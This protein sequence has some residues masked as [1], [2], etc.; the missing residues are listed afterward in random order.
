M[1]NKKTVCS[2]DMCTGCMACVQKCPNKAIKIYD[3]ILCFNAVIQV[4]KCID[5]GQCYN[6]CQKNS[7][8]D[9]IYPVSWYQGWAEDEK[10][11]MSGS[12]GGVATALSQAFI[13]NGGVVCSCLFEKGDFVFD[14][15]YTIEKTKRFS[16][17][18]YVKS[19]PDGIYK[20]IEQLLKEKKVLF[21]GLP[22]QVAALIKYISGELKQNLYT[23]DLICHGTPSK[24]V[25]EEYLLQHNLNLFEMQS[26][27]FRKKHHYCL[28]DGEKEI[29]AK[30]TCDSYSMSF[31]NSLILTENCYHCDYAKTERVSDITLGDSWGSQLDVAE[32]KKG[33]SL[34]LCQTEKGQEIIELS[35]IHLENV[36]LERAISNNK[37]LCR[38]SIKTE[39]RDVLLRELIRGKGYDSLIF[40]LLPKSS[41][42][43]KIK[44]LL[45][46]FKSL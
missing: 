15:A 18:K 38:P 37:Q 25:L 6:V 19:N 40:K 34:I 13:E 9:L 7:S 30:G 17:S 5:C 28:S 42:K 36:D 43:Q 45:Y 20:Q 32:Q 21:I 29:A 16:G 27:E 10:V 41:I 39:R 24:K 44:G 11:R 2:I 3:D 23:V 12:S 31:L 1:K 26:I 8:V 14:I 4:D 35:K 33:L 46:G 22:C